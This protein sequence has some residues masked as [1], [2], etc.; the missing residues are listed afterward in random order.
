[1]GVRD[2]QDEVPLPRTGLLQEGRPL[3][4]RQEAVERCIEGE[5]APSVTGNDPEPRQ[6][7][8][9]RPL[10][11][12]G[13]R[14]EA[15]PGERGTAG[16]AQRLEMRAGEGAHLGVRELTARSTSSIPKRRSGLS[17]P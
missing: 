1:M 15:R 5:P 17:V 8:R 12:L 4:L 16:D 6:P 14:V 3:D 7:G 9:T 2:G 10:G 11:L 13:Q